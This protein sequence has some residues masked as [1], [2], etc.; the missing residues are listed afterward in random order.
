MDF[1]LLSE[2]IAMN[3][4]ARNN[5]E[6]LFYG[7]RDR[8][9]GVG[10]RGLT[11]AGLSSFLA[12]QG[13]ICVLAHLGCWHNS[14]VGSQL[15][16]VPISLDSPDISLNLKVCNLNQGFRVTFAR[17]GDIYWVQGFGCEHP[18]GLTAIRPATGRRCYYPYF[19][20]EETEMWRG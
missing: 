5:T 11:S 8:K 2:Q 17:E 7:S 19:T 20:D 6:L 1:L 14:V 18:R 9:F 12:A 10:L 4:V 13:G 16:A 3:L 15:R